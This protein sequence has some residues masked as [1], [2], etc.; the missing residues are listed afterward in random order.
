MCQVVS[1]AEE[2]VIESSYTYEDSS[3]Q[4]FTKNKDGTFKPYTPNRL[5]DKIIAWWTHRKPPPDRR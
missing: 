2:P 1:R 5:R 3:P 4:L